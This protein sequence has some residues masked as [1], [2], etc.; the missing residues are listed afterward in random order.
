M[1]SGAMVVVEVGRENSAEMALTEDDDM[2][3]ALTPHRADQS[4]DE[5]VLPGLLT[6]QPINIRLIRR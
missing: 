6:V 1:R 3:E 2:V 5:G 4:L